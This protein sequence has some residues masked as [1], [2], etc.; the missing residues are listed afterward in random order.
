ME[1]VR[2]ML[3]SIM[4]FFPVIAIIAMIAIRLT[5][6]K[7]II[8]ISWDKLAQFM[9]GLF[10]LAMVRLLAYQFLFDTGNLQSFPSLPEVIESHKWTLGLVFG[11]ICFS[12]YLYSLFGNI[13]RINGCN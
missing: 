12:V 6:D 7:E 1:Y 8:R 3:R 11:K 2:E 10:V 4:P 13:S 9:T 5:K